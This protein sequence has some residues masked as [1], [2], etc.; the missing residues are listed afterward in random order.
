MDN[1]T[2]CECWL[3]IGECYCEMQTKKVDDKKG[4]YSGNKTER[5]K[6]SIHN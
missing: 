4:K 2:R 1:K 6:S 5:G 3:Q